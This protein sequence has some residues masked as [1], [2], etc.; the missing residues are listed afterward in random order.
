VL[1]RVTQLLTPVVAIALL[2]CG[3]ESKR[4]EVG[5][6]IRLWHTFNPSE[7][8]ELNRTVLAG[9]K[10][11]VESTLLP[12]GRA[13]TI[14]VQALQNKTDC[15][16]LARIDATWLPRLAGLDALQP[17]P[18]SIAATHRWLPEAFSL[19]SIDGKQLALP[20]GIDGLALIHRK[21]TAA[22]AGLDWPPKTIDTLLAD[23]RRMTQ[24]G[25]YGLAVRRDGYW[26][27]A[28]LRAW[29]GEVVDPKTGALNIDSDVAVRALKR[30]ARLFGPKG[31]A[32]S[33]SR[34]EREA[35]DHARGFRS[36]TIKVVLDGPWAVSALGGGSAKG[37]AVTPFPAG[38]NGG[39]A[40]RGGQLLVVPRCAKKPEAAWK[41]ALALVAPDLQADWG[42]RYGLVPTTQKGLA[43]AG[44]FTQQFYRALQEARPLPRHPVSAE[45][46][47]DLNPAI[48]AVISGDA[49][50]E[51]AL[52]GVRRAWT[53]LLKRHGVIVKQDVKQ[54][55]DA[56]TP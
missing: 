51:E 31:V 56:G 26:F 50:A 35:S 11:R 42:Q 30:F 47:D 55:K 6:R 18:R 29:G 22:A 45:L 2:A 24:G 12:F 38:P 32:P 36:N 8:R 7:T 53:R 17:P 27:V 21:T 23:A 16:D 41:L 43:G 39:A 13:Q 20:Q 52:A 40:P 49:T 48:S 34:V 3:S 10:L 4:P 19:A 1:P 46:F 14:L 28:F 9:A 15:P 54:E 5:E 33:P 44:A 37:L 25:N